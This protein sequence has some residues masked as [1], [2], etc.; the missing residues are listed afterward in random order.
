[1]TS[2]CADKNPESTSEHITESLE[3]EVE[4]KESTPA[5]AEEQQDALRDEVDWAAKCAEQE[6]VITDLAAQLARL[7]ADFDNY[8]RRT[9][10]E[11]EEITSRAG[12]KLI[13]KMLPVLDNLDRACNATEQGGS[14][15]SIT[16][17]IEL[18]RRGLLD[19]L[20]AEGLEE[21]PG[22]GALFDPYIHEAVDRSDDATTHVVAVYQKGYKLAGRVLRAAMVKVG[23]EP[24]ADSDGQ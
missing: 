13:T 12:E 1:M 9:K 17:G 22:V 16:A 8:R 19:I 11:I 10:N 20:A 5:Q 6:Q 3:S 2:H 15:E 21:V 14:L 7:R 23:P 24:A 18:V 4:T